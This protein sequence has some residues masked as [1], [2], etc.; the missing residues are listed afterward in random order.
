[1]DVLVD[2]NVLLR[3]AEPGHAQYPIAKSATEALIRSGLRLCVVPQVYYEF[4]A[5]YTRPVA[6]NGLGK[7]P[8]EAAKELV[9]LKSIFALLPDSGPIFTQWE[10]L[11]WQYGV[12]GKN[13]HDAR[14]VAA[15]LVHGVAQLLTF[16]AADF[17]RYGGITVL[18]P[19]AIVVPVTPPPP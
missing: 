19:T 14:L 2:T 15:M 16:N 17:A 1:M 5:V 9:A 10:S 8:V 18:D 3:R 6:A 12:Q 11:V 4:W 13:T 7:S